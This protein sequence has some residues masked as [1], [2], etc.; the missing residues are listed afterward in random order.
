MGWF[1]H[2]GLRIEFLL[3]MDSGYP[4]EMRVKTMENTGKTQTP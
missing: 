3:K 2:G 1:F 4:K